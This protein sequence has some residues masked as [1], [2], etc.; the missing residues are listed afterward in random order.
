MSAKAFLF[1]ASLAAIFEYMKAM[2]RKFIAFDY[3]KSRLNEIL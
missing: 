3:V 1:M 2:Y